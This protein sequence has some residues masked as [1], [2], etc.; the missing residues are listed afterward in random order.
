MHN[1]HAHNMEQNLKEENA[2]QNYIYK[3]KPQGVPCTLEATLFNNC[4]VLC[5]LG[6]WTQQFLCYNHQNEVH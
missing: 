1:I 2:Q 6:A 4:V 5:T 3:N